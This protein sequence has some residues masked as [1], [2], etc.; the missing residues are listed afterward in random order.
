MIENFGP[1]VMEELELG[2]NALRALK[3]DLVMFSM[4]AAG[5]TGPL[6]AIRTYGLSLTSTTG[7]DSLGPV[8]QGIDGRRRFDPGGFRMGCRS[9]PRIAHGR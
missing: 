6:K 4:P 8:S 3:S 1:G 5:L 9:E 7:L 2:W